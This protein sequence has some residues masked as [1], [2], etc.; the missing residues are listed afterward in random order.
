MTMHER[1]AI[2]SIGDELTLGQSLDTNSQWLSQQL[3]DRGIVP[4][5]H[6]TVP[7][8]EDAIV[9]AFRRVAGLEGGACAGAHGGLGPTADDL[10]RGALA[11]VFDETLME[12]VQALAAIERWFAERGR[13]M[14]SVNRVQAMR[15]RSA[16]VLANRHGTAPGLGATLANGVDVWCLP[17]P[18]G[19]MRAMFETEI[20]PHLRVATDRPVQV[21]VVLTFGLGE[22]DIAER[23]GGLMDR[24]RNPL[25]GTTVSGGHVACRIRYEAKADESVDASR[26][27]VDEAE[28]A[29]REAIGPYVI[30]SGET[31]LAQSVMEMLRERRNTIS[32]A[33]SCTGGMLGSLLTDVPGA[34]SVFAGG[35]IAY[36]NDVKKR[37]LS[38]P[39]S[40]LS[41]GAPGAVSRD[42]AEAMAQGC[43]A[44]FETD[45]A[46]AITGIAGPDGGT[47]EKPVGTVWITVA[48]RAK[49]V[50]TIESRRF[51]LG[52]G[53]SAIRDWSAKLALGMI[54]FRLLER[55]STVL[56]RE[57]ERHASEVTR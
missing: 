25:V 34:S 5:E 9:A 11:R 32:V 54:R 42:C 7:D 17:G 21:R 49:G 53:R 55:S 44:R 3:L 45:H 12:D 15:P 51:V 40:L 41:E 18:P 22:S 2:V 36:S 39:E 26:S 30:G 13:A 6:V 46:L 52:P 43:L 10:T 8:D 29:V 24:D 47:A 38:V 20:V 28:R 16:R 37:F 48:S 33:E 31:S 23:L 50:T 27:V 56:I 14:P 35:V 1:A 19:E 57:R 4:V